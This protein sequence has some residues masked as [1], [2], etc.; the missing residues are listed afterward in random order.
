MSHLVRPKDT[1]DRAK[2]DGVVYRIP[3]ECR[4]V[5]VGET[6]RSLQERIKEHDR[7]IPLARTQTSTV[8]EHAN[9]TVRHPLWNEL[10]FIDRNSHWYTRVKEAIHKTLHSDNINRDNE[11]EMPESWITTIK[12]HNR[13]PVRQRTAVGA[14]SNWTSQ[15][16]TSTPNNEDRNPPITA[17]HRNIYG[18]A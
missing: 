4:R 10:K 14:T 1:V 6:G 16:T 12:T 5:N 15:E 17:S 3:C 2:Q 13:R 8:S 7:D 9:K 11:I 18:D